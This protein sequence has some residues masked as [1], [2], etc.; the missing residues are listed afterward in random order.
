MLEQPEGTSVE[1]QGV[2]PE[3]PGGSSWKNPINTYINSNI[4]NQYINPDTGPNEIENTLDEKNQNTQE[5]ESIDIDSGRLE[6]IPTDF[7]EIYFKLEKSGQMSLSYQESALYWKYIDQF[8]ELIN[9]SLELDDDN[10][11]S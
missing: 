1:N 5:R 7:F 2:V 6:K 8:N 11:R 9:S 10:I 4:L 3:R